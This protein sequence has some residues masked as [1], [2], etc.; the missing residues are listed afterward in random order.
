MQSAINGAHG[1]AHREN[2]P[3]PVRP[4]MMTTEQSSGNTKLTIA[5]YAGYSRN[6]EPAPRLLR[7]SKSRSVVGME[8]FVAWQ[9]ECFSSGSAGRRR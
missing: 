3:A 1:Y 8:D 5:R 7:I 2:Q 6:S 4:L 9:T